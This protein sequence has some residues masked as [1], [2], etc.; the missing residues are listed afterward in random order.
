MR[1]IGLSLG[2]SGLIAFGT[3]A[4][5][6]P[7]GGNRGLDAEFGPYD[8]AKASAMIR[9]CN[10]QTTQLRGIL[11]FWRESTDRFKAAH[12]AFM[13]QTDE[14]D[15]ASTALGDAEIR[16][17]S[18]SGEEA[19]QFRSNIL[20][21][22]RQRYQQMHDAGID[23]SFR[24]KSAEEQFSRDTKVVTDFL[25]S[26]GLKPSEY[27]GSPNVVLDRQLEK[28]VRVQRWAS[29]GSVRRAEEREPAPISAWPD[30]AIDGWK[31]MWSCRWRSTGADGTVETDIGA[32]ASAFLQDDGAV[33]VNFSTE[34][35]RLAS[36]PSGHA[37]HL[38]SPLTVQQS[39]PTRGAFTNRDGSGEDRA[40]PDAIDSG[41]ISGDGRLRFQ[42]RYSMQP[43]RQDDL[44]CTR[45][46]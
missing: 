21:P 9:D 17:R 40:A 31:G 3:P 7:A 4:P 34:W 29:Q 14:T 25:K 27:A 22:R 15:R 11:A 36:W 1:R 20:E 37:S 44:E 24:R 32:N 6:Q 42:R 13:R 46:R 5:G 35:V 30:G 45:A 10:A 23:E 26:I 2:L 43:D 19:E 16:M 41:A 39:Q 12:A 8:E 28:C 18:L 33:V 38:F